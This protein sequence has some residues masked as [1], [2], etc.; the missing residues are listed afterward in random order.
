M[1]YA[2]A[3]SNPMLSR[4]PSS[5]R[6][7]VSTMACLH[8]R[9]SRLGGLSGAGSIA[10]RA[11]V[12]WSAS[13]CCSGS[14]V[15]RSRFLIFFLGRWDGGAYALIMKHE[16]HEAHKIVSDFTETSSDM[17]HRQ[18]GGLPHEN[19]VVPAGS[20]LQTE[21]RIANGNSHLSKYHR[22]LIDSYVCAGTV[23][24]PSCQ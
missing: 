7:I 20:E 16:Y 23:N 14:R 4:I 18:H 9:L 11:A 6:S 5:P 3:A 2:I 21:Y 17:N 22:S 15:G 1:A 19:V 8:P 24:L 13:P 12:A 10:P